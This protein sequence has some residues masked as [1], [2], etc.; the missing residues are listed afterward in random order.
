MSWI[1]TISKLIPHILTTYSLKQVRLMLFFYGIFS[2][3][4]A[5]H[6]S[7]P[8]G[9]NRG[10]LTII[11]CS[12]LICKLRI[13]SRIVTY[14]SSFSTFERQTIIQW[15][16]FKSQFLL[17]IDLILVQIDSLLWVLHNHDN[18]LLWWVLTN[19]E[20]NTLAHYTK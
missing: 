5:K 14:F 15:K 16:C 7:L 4:L 1:F 2:L 10:K 8:T 12:S 9:E 6:T 11:S 13:Q 3:I 18:G 20:P 19:N 17:T